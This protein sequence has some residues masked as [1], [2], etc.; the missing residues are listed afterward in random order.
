MDYENTLNK[1][2]YDFQ[3]EIHIY[4]YANVLQYF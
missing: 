1:D 4:Y 2:R 3:I